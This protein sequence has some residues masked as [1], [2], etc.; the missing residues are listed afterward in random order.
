MA[1]SAF[2]C[3][4]LPFTDVT[5]LFDDFPLFPLDVRLLLSDVF[6]SLVADVTGA[7][8]DFL[9]DLLVAVFGHANDDTDVAS[10]DD[11]TFGVELP[12]AVVVVAVEDLADDVTGVLL[13][14]SID[15]E[16][17]GRDV[18]RPPNGDIQG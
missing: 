12:L 9:E 5:F 3:D 2:A 6:A 7:V 16:R 1:A 10:G 14:E 11:V 15:E 8:V 18:G 13:G 17:G 4:A